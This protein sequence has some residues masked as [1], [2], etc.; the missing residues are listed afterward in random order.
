MIA[1]TDDNSQSYSKDEGNGSSGEN[2]SEEGAEAANDNNTGNDNEGYSN[3]SQ[4]E[5]SGD[6]QSMSNKLKV[7]LNH[8]KSGNENTQLWGSDELWNTIIADKIKDAQ[9]AN[10]WG[11]TPGS[12][13]D[14]ILA[15]LKPKINYRRLLRGFRASIISS[16]RRLTRMK[17]SRRYGFQYWGSHYDFSTRLLFAVDVS[18]S[19]SD[20]DLSRGFSAINQF[21]K[22]GIETLDV[23]EFDTKIKG[24]PIEFKKARK[25][26]EVKGRGGTDYTDVIKYI[27]KHRQYDGLIIFTDGY[28]NKPPYPKNKKTKILWLFNSENNYNKMKG[29]VEYTGKAT[30]L[31]RQ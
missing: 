17:P 11:D 8:I 30:F 3:E 20:K 14:I 23:I 10:S 25:E 6:G 4:G 27:D 1:G 26:I 28:A 29:N 19:I 2:Q 18:G 9:Q 12:F 7:Y 24:E 21:F 16:K 22:Y 15:T 5:G 31:Q 13:K